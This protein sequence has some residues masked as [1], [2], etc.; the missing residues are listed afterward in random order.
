MPLKLWDEAFLATV[1]LINCTPN[2]LLAFSTPMEC[3]YNKNPDYTF[4]RV[5]GSACLPNL[6]PYN[7]R[8]LQFRSKQYA[9]LGHNNLHKGY[10]CL[11][12]S[13][14]RAY[15][16]SD[17][18]FD[19]HI[20][21]L[22]K[23]HSNASALLRS[24]IILLLAHLGNPS[25]VDQREKSLDQLTNT[26]C[27]SHESD[28]SFRVNMHYFMQEEPFVSSQGTNAE[29]ETD[30]A[31]DPHAPSVMP[32]PALLGR[33]AS[34]SASQHDPPAPCGGQQS[35]DARRVDVPRETPGQPRNAM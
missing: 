29:N 18:I 32:A 1:C 24:Q 33:S 9:F 35:A 3:L 15:I 28:A 22:S 10:K 34:Q 20:F 27:D 7:T 12:I 2:K 5:F 13:T 25:R 30:L 17:V 14:G 11:D 26:P 6:R 16:S 8:K 21:P 31:I 23:L 4:L 19:E